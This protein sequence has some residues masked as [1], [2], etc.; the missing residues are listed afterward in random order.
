[1]KNKRGFGKKAILRSEFV[2][3]IIAVLC[4]LLLIYLAFVLYGMFIKNSDIEQAKET[5]EQIGNL[6]EGLDEGEKAN[7][8]VVAPKGWALLSEGKKL[9]MCNFENI[10]YIGTRQGYTAFQECSEKGVL[11]SVNVDLKN[12]HLCRSVA[13]EFE[14]CF[15]FEEV[16]V[17]IYLEKKQGKVYIL[18]KE[19]EG[20]DSNK[21]VLDYK[22]DEN[23]KTLKE[24]ILEAVNLL[25]KGEDSNVVK[26]KIKE[27][28]DNHF[29]KLDTNERFGL[30]KDKT[31]WAF[32]IY[33]EGAEEPVVKLWRKE[34]ELKKSLTQ[35]EIYLDEN[36]RVVLNYYEGEEIV[37][38]VT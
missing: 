5:L 31:S 7:Y 4:L 28:L 3:L 16:P 8:L 11:K 36:Y 10:D 1:M 24:L 30:D 22:V 26:E 13:N 12:F 35:Q 18:G 20:I 21:E 37:L 2:R 25:G 32:Y 15:W 34:Y 6:I 14:A 38:I 17:R 27:N 19:S 23:S 33:R 9:A 29:E